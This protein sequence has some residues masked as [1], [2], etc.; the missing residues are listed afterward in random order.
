MLISAVE[1]S[2]LCIY[3]HTHTHTHTQ[4]QETWI[5][6]LGQVDPLEKEMATHSSILAWKT[7]WIEEPG[8]LQS[9]SWQRAGHNWATDHALKFILVHIYTYTFFFIFLSIITYLG[10]LKV[11]SD[12]VFH[13]VSLSVVDWLL[14][15]QI[16]ATFSHLHRGSWEWINETLS[17]FPFPDAPDEQQLITGSLCALS[18]N[19]I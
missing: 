9:M 2:D 13:L 7:P 12:S 15:L 17:Q 19:R 5:R 11:L 6:S 3:I 4:T 18:Y 8:G 16:F 14:C 10:V 1:Q